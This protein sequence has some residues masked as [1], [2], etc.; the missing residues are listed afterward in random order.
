MTITKR[1]LFEKCAAHLLRQGEKSTVRPGG[2][3]CLYRNLDGLQC[4]IGPLIEDPW[5][6]QELEGEPFSSY[7]VQL[8]VGRSIGRPLEVDERVMLEKM[9]KIHDKGQPQE[10]PVLIANLRN[11]TFELRRMQNRED[12]IDDNLDANT[13]RLLDQIENG[14]RNT[15]DLLHLLR[16]AYRRTFELGGDKEV[17][18]FHDELTERFK[19]DGDEKEE[20]LTTPVYT[21]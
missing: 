20:G 4:A 7:Q 18:K 21:S 5:Y 11:E 13:A 6:S 10:W 19:E 2:A 1:E 3:S 17:Q 9:Q 12:V 14:E 8:A 15:D 16:V